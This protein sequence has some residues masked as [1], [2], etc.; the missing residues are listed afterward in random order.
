MTTPS[1]YW[2]QTS[3]INFP[4]YEILAC[5]HC[6]KKTHLKN[7]INRSY[8]THIQV[9]IKLKE[10]KNYKYNETLPRKDITHHACHGQ[11]A[12]FEVDITPVAQTRVQFKLRR[13]HKIL[14]DK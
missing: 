9:N 6:F 11:N 4:E 8:T 12:P 7:D 2:K 13:K 14:N 10:K 5:L 1:P 3:A